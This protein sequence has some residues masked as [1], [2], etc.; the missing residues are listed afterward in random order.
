MRP[1]NPPQ[2]FVVMTEDILHCGIRVPLLPYFPKMLAYYRVSPM[3]LTPN[4]YR[5]MAALLVA[6]KLLGFLELTRE[7]F[8]FIYSLKENTGDHSFYHSSKWHFCDV[9]AFWNIKSTIGQWKYC[10]FQMESPIS[11]NFRGPSL[12]VIFSSSF[13][14]LTLYVSNPFLLFFCLQLTVPT[15]YST[16]NSSIE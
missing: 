13:I 9:K 3:Y 12:L 2:G 8:V 11:G 16:S 14:F 1:H 5:H 10:W 15:P 7:E 6:Y 4:S